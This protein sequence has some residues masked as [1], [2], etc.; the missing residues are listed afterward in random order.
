[1]QDNIGK[2][3][4]N[5]R[6]GVIGLGK[7]GMCLAGI[8]VQK[9]EVYGVDII[10][11]DPKDNED[12]ELQKMDLKKLVTSTDFSMLKD[13]EVVFNV[14]N[15]P[16]NLDGSFSN[17][18]IY[19]SIEKARP[20]LNCKVFVVVS[21][22]MPGSCREI[23]KI[24][25]CEICYNP[26]FIRL[27]HVIND[28]LNPD[29]ILIGEENKQSGDLIEKIYREITDA[30]IK[31]MDLISAEIAKI[32]LNAYITMKISFANVLDEICE[33]LGGNAKKITEAI[34]EDKRIGKRYFK[35]GGA[36]GGPCFPRD[37]RAFA[38][39]AGNI[40]NYAELTDKINK[41]QAERIGFFTKNKRYGTLNGEG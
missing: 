5:M 25:P 24:L 10:Q 13:C 22:V 33:K 4:E 20:Y 27:G 9:N 39:F 12:A 14:V 38:V 3:E 8:L 1:M 23:S 29:F 2:R 6:I 17:E 15:T 30:P 34:G 28:M 7:L 16:S 11:R 26:E 41:H 31:R 18:S 19:E 36:Y 32:S 40:P 35:P 21:T 37:N